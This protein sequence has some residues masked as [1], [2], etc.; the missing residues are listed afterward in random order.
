MTGGSVALAGG[1][2]LRYMLLGRA[3]RMIADRS[4]VACV[5]CA[6]RAP[7]TNDE[8]VQCMNTECKSWYCRACYALQRNKP[9]TRCELTMTG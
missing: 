6:R 8:H 3:V 4:H 9:C 7:L 2:R 5:L 1:G